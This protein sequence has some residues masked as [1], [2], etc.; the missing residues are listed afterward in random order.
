MDN[1]DE[2]VLLI[3]SDPTTAKMIRE[4]LSEARY[5]P[6]VIEWA[7]TLSAGPNGSAGG[8]LKAICSIYP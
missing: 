4:E 2:I 8:G 7:E 5:G 1:M 3:E 6:Y